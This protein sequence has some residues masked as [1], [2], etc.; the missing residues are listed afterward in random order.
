LRSPHVKTKV[1]CQSAHCRL[2]VLGLNC[3]FH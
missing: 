1:P 2:A 3:G